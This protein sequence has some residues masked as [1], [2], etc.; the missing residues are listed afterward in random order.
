MPVDLVAP[1]AGPT[2]VLEGSAS[3]PFFLD[4][5]R[6]LVELGPDATAVVLDG[7]DHG[8]PP[9]IVAPVVAEFVTS[10]RCTAQGR[11]R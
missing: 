11:G 10:P 7:Q 9:E 1:V 5:A 2:L 8:T 3:P 6:R 4:T